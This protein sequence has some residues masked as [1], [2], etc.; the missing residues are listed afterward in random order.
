MGNGQSVFSFEE[1]EQASTA[2]TAR[3]YAHHGELIQGVFEQ[4]D[5]RLKR[6]LITLPLRSKNAFAV[7]EPSQQ[8]GVEV[9]PSDRI[10]AARAA[11]LALDYL[12]LGERGGRLALRSQIPI[13]HGYGS[14]SA[15]VIASIRAVFDAFSR[16]VSAA[17]TSKLAVAAEAASDAIAFEESSILFAHREGGVVEY[18]GGNL[19]PFALVSFKA[20]NP[21]PISTTALRRARYDAEE[22][23]VFR[24][25]LGTVRRAVRYQDPTLLGRATTLSARISQRHLPK[26]GF[27]QALAICANHSVNGLQVSHSGSLF[28]ILVDANRP[29]LDRHLADIVGNLNE[30]GFTQV[31]QF[32]ITAEANLL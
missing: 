3:A 9:M 24:C 4:H 17:L 15:D 16:T 11:E 30:A 29:Q 28:G 21:S 32:L 12:K 25:A 31:E 1:L 22:I 2:G 19:P 20:P 8:A 26:S 27:N 14:S 6:A 23:Q 18:L 7:F 13:G 5:G 10:K